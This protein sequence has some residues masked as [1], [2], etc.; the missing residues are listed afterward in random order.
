MRFATLLP[1]LV[2]GIFLHA[3]AQSPKPKSHEDGETVIHIIAVNDK[4]DVL[5]EPVVTPTL[6]FHIEQ[7]S[8]DDVGVADCIQKHETRTAG[9]WDYQ[10]FVLDCS[11][12][13]I[14]L[15]DIDMRT[16]R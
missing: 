9:K 15:S 12:T 13:K 7:G 14:V 16:K 4:G 6:E 11:G 8:I 1:L 5:V 10:A 3:F 2:A